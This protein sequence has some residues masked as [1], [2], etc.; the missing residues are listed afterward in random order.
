MKKIT[1]RELEVLNLLPLSNKKI[2]SKLFITIATVKTHIHNLLKK[3]G[4]KSRIELYKII[5]KE[6]KNVK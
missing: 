5:I 2:A 4:V 3:F 6:R 1:K